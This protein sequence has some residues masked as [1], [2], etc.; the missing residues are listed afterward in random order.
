MKLVFLSNYINPH[1]MPMAQEF[2]KIFGDD[3][4]FIATTPTNP[5]ALVRTGN[6]DMN[7]DPCVLRAYENQE[8]M[9]LAKKLIVESEHLIIGGTPI[10][11]FWN[12]IEQRIKNGKILFEY[13]ERIFKSGVMG[14]NTFKKIKMLLAS[15]FSPLKKHVLLRKYKG[16]NARP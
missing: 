2:V 5:H 11:P 14:P 15:R 16:S 10:D 6:Y 13:S 1:Q 9:Q 3:Y 4:R 8:N 12:I 7:Q